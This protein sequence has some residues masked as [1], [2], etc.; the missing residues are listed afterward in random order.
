MARTAEKEHSVGSLPSPTVIC[1]SVIFPCATVALIASAVGGC[2]GTSSGSNTVAEQALRDGS[3]RSYPAMSG[4]SS[5]RRAMKGQTGSRGS[6]GNA[7]RTRNPARGEHAKSSGQELSMHAFRSRVNAVCRTIR[8]AT[9]APLAARAD[10]RMRR[11]MKARSA[12]QT[13]GALTRFTPP[14]ALQIRMAQLLDALQRLEQLRVTDPSDGVDGASGSD[15]RGLVASAER[16]VATDAAAA[17]LPD[18]APGDL[19][20]PRPFHAPH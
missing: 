8:S 9:P 14:P 4:S 3:P 18:C 2:G 11:Q 7:R 5:V 16:Q 12:Q 13:I 19:P 15:L 1:K 20:T 10:A 17:G 6:G